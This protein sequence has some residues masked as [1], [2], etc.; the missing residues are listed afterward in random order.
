MMDRDVKGKESY[1]AS[2]PHLS[3]D[4]DMPGNMK[5]LLSPFVGDFRHDLVD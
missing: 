1:K 3:Q 4:R 2:F 5:S